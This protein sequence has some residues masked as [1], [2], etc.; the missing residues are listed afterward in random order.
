MFISRKGLRYGMMSGITPICCL[1]PID[2]G[3]S[4][5]CALKNVDRYFIMISVTVI[6]GIWVI[7][8]K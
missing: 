4:I 8:Q 2:G 5:D 3:N 1:L 6:L 7:S